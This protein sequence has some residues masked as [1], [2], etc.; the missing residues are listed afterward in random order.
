MAPA[1][2][3]VGVLN[4][5][6]IIVRLKAKLVLV[7]TEPPLLDEDSMPSFTAWPRSLMTEPLTAVTKPSVPVIDVTGVAVPPDMNVAAAE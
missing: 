5:N 1:I 3:P 4:L 6:P 2:T 7:L